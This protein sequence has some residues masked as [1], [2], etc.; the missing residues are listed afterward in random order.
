[1]KTVVIP[2]SK[3]EKNNID[4]SCPLKVANFTPIVKSVF[5]IPRN[6]V[7][8]FAKTAVFLSDAA[9]DAVQK[10]LHL[11]NTSDLL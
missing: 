11:A 9:A 3:K 7:F 10:L 8:S 2:N 4:W 5:V 6:D 1:M